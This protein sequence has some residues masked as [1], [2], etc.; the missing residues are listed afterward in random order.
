MR[1]LGLTACRGLGSQ[2]SMRENVSNEFLIKFYLYNI[3]RINIDVYYNIISMLKRNERRDNVDKGILNVPYFTNPELILYKYF[4]FLNPENDKKKVIKLMLLLYTKNLREYNDKRIYFYNSSVH[5]NN[6]IF[7]NFFNYHSNFYDQ[8]RKTKRVLNLKIDRYNLYTDFFLY[9]LDFYLYHL[10]KNCR[11]L[12]IGQLNIL[13]NIY[14]NISI[15]SEECS[16][17]YLQNDKSSPFTTCLKNNSDKLYRHGDSVLKG[18][19]TCVQT[20]SY[21]RE[22]YI[23][24]KWKDECVN[25]FEN[26]VNNKICLLFIQISRGIISQTVFHVNHK[27]RGE[28]DKGHQSTKELT[29]SNVKTCRIILNRLLNKS[30]KKQYQEYII[31]KKIYNTKLLNINVLKNYLNSIKYLNIINIKK[32][33]Y[34]ILYLYFNSFLFKKS[35]YFTSLIFHIL[36]KYNLQYTY[37]F[38]ILFIKFNLFFVNYKI[39][40]ECNKIVLLDGISKYIDSVLTFRIKTCNGGGSPTS[41]QVDINP[42]PSQADTNPTS[43]QADINPT[44]SQ[45]DE[46]YT[47]IY[48][49]ERTENVYTQ[50]MLHEDV[51][52]YAKRSSNSFTYFEYSIY[53]LFKYLNYNIIFVKGEKKK[54]I[55]GKTNLPEEDNNFANTHTNYVNKKYNKFYLTLSENFLSNIVLLSNYVQNC[56]PILFSF[57]QCIQVVRLR[58]SRRKNKNRKMTKQNII[59]TQHT[60][61]YTLFPINEQNRKTIDIPH[62]HVFKNNTFG[63]FLQKKYK[64]KKGKGINPFSI[65]L[66]YTY[67]VF[68]QKIIN[69]YLNDENK[70]P[71]KGKNWEEEIIMYNNIK[72][73]RNNKIRT[74][75]THY[76]ISSNFK[77]ISDKNLFNEK[78]IL[79]FYCD[80]YFNNNIIEVD[81]PKHFFIYYH[82]EKGIKQNYFTPFILKHRD[83]FDFNFVFPFFFHNENVL[84]LKDSQNGYYYFYN[85]KSVKKNFFLYINGY[86]I[87]HINYFDKDITSY[88]Y[89]FDVLFRRRSNFHVATSGISQKTYS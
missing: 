7:H 11:L 31:L 10:S 71:K 33:V 21:E 64:K 67:N 38:S 15:S 6:F 88:N 3:S 75:L 28:Y 29:Q 36:Q 41:S 24:K 51:Y 63:K 61:E 80:I 68:R 37:L 82:F 48:N 84:N 40:N 5:V 16:E 22:G 54:K 59:H 47:H 58:P 76:Y 34:I 35:F 53:N 78:N 44:P 27:Y 32:Y 87:K 66:T 70:F 12:N 50:K 26:N 23:Q 62:A 69:N 18:N 57:M 73:N 86:F 25:I 20:C 9:A 55:N 43:S 19:A 1:L 8:E 45:A 4:R 83:I 77:K 85:D 14:A 13:S 39:L 2:I 72:K 30:I 17:A 52:K 42:T 79:T 74:S 46:F 81:G 56:L 49:K 65:F 89:L 60:R